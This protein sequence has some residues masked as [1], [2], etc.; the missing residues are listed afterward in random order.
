MLQ[1]LLTTT[2]ACGVAI[3]LAAP[4]FA[5]GPT[6]VVI[7][8]PPMAPVPAPV[9]GTDWTGGYVGGQLGWGWAGAENDELEA[10]GDGVIGGL[11]AGYRY[12]FGRFVL[13]AEA[14]YDWAD[15]EL[16]DAEL[17]GADIDLGDATPSLDSVARI[18][19]TAG[20]DAGRAL[21]YGSAGWARATIQA[22]GE[23]ES[24]DGWVVGAGVDYLL[25]DR[26]TIGGEVM[27]HR[28]DDFN[29]SG[30]D[31]D[32]TTLQARVTYNF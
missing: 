20:Y 10:D 15:I 12:D 14:Q 4:A 1:R 6:P 29:D 27:H 18:K 23:D 11:T 3:A 9:L 5:A 2:A 28:F 8:Q 25:T 24:D 32:A 16:D 19:A 21:V 13:G 30:A 26:I 31:V 7:E 22:D 17:A